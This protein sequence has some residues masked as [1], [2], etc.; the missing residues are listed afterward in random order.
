[1]TLFATYCVTDALLS[2][3]VIFI[4]QEMEY[5][6][7]YPSVLACLDYPPVVPSEKVRCVRQYLIT[8]LY[9]LEFLC[10]HF[11]PLWDWCQFQSS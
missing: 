6:K 2:M 10:V 5:G 7:W 9:W 11:L 3:Y 8:D 1:M 4:L